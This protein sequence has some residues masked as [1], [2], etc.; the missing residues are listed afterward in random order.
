MI[1]LLHC[2]YALPD[3][4]QVAQQSAE[5]MPKWNDSQTLFVFR[6]REENF[7]LVKETILNFIVSL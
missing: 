3:Q 6:V 4:D 7:T 1:V 2:Y 5:L